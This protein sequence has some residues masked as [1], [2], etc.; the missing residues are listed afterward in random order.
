[1]QSEWRFPNFKVAIFYM[2]I[3][4]SEV[5]CNLSVTK[6]M[7]FLRGVCLNVNIGDMRL[8]FKLFLCNIDVNELLFQAEYFPSKSWQSVSEDSLPKHKKSA[9]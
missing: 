6:V 3:L 2:V 1:M 8:F 9:R 4:R 5:H 7:T